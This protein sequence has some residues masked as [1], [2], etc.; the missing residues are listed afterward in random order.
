MSFGK[1]EMNSIRG[2]I[3]GLVGIFVVAF[4]YSFFLS[5]SLHTSSRQLF[6]SCDVHWHCERKFLENIAWF[7]VG[8]NEVIWIYDL[9][10]LSYMEILIKER[11]NKYCH[12][13]VVIIFVLISRLCKVCEKS[14]TQIFIHEF[15]NK[16][17]CNAWGHWAFGRN[18]E[19]SQCLQR[20]R[21]N[22]RKYFGFEKSWL[23]AAA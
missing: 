1:V 6:I 5:L 17:N 15:L 7:V 23:K 13:N 2:V 9:F 20:R 16:S 14:A 11:L 18:L 21:H 19:N 4:F 10:G 12:S 22:N 8:G 3:S